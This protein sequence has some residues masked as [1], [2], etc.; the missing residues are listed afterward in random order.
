MKP[1]GPSAAANAERPSAPPRERQTAEDGS[2][3]GRHRPRFS[4]AADDDD[5]IKTQNCAAGRRGKAWVPTCTSVCHPRHRAIGVGFGPSDRLT[6]DEAG[7]RRRP[8][9]DSES[10]GASGPA[11]TDSPIRLMSDITKNVISLS[12]A[13][14]CPPFECYNFSVG[15]GRLSA[16]STDIVAHSAGSPREGLWPR[17]GERSHVGAV[18]RRRCATEARVHPPGARARAHACVRLDDAD[19]V[20]HVERVVVS[21]EPH[22]GLLLAVRADERVH[23]IR[24]RGHRGRGGRRCRERRLM[25]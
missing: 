21:G 18:S 25:V 6:A 9:S 23:L 22:V 4:L 24:L 1:R 16:Q 14:A 12:A 5:S 11:L 3:R 20:G 17:I 2:R 7:H 15:Y 13:A 8:G 19:L 10:A